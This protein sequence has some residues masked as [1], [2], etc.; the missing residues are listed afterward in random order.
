[1]K[2]RLKNVPIKMKGSLR[3]APEPVSMKYA[4]WGLVSGM[5]SILAI[6]A[7]TRMAGYPLLIGSFGASAVLLFGADESPLAQPRNLVGG[8]L[9][10]ALVAVG[11]VSLF[12]STPEAIAFAVGIAIFVMYLTRTIHPPGG[13]TALIGVQSHA[14]AHFVLVPVLSGSLVLLAVALFTNNVVYHRQYPKNWL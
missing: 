11:I 4:V 13:A 6:F 5:S 1:M 7:M 8:H 2:T 12:G 10:S 9:F 14:T 3:G